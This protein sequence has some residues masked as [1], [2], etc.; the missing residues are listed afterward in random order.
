MR[1]PIISRIFSPS[2]LHDRTKQVPWVR[3]RYRSPSLKWKCPK[4]SPRIAF[5]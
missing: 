2:G 5:E 4:D 3:F 1:R